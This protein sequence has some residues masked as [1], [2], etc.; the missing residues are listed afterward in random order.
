L[1]EIKQLEKTLQYFPILKEDEDW[2]YGFFLNLI[3][4]KLK[5]MSQYFHTHNIVENEDWY[6]TLCD[7]TINILHTGYKTNIILSKDLGEIKVNTRNVYR[8]FT[9]KQLDFMLKEGLQKYYLATVRETKA[10]ALF[11]RYL[12]HHIEEL[13][14]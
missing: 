11:W 1:K 13:W 10:K 14:D 9:P 4:F 5:R 6:G 8:F 12:E 2:D 3:E 7:R